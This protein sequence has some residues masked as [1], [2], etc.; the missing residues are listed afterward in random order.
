MNKASIENIFS[1]CVVMVFSLSNNEKVWLTAQGEKPAWQ[2]D[3]I[4]KCVYLLSCKKN[5][6]KLKQNYPWV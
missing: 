3:I 6:V 2:N 1:H 4:F 5:K